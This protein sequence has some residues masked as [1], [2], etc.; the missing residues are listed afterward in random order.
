[1]RRTFFIFFLLLAIF[2]NLPS[3]FSQDAVYVSDSK[4]RQAEEDSR[5]NPIIQDFVQK[6]VTYTLIQMFG[7]V[8]DRTIHEQNIQ[9]VPQIAYSAAQQATFEAIK[10]PALKEI[11]LD[12]YNKGF[13]M[14]IEERD[15]QTPPAA[16]EQMVRR[17]ARS[18]LQRVYDLNEF[19]FLT[20]EILRQAIIQQQQIML[21]YAYQSQ[22]QKMV[23]E[24]EIMN[25]AIQKQYTQAIQNSMIK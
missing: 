1:M 8:F 3:A 18:E 20:E 4:S 24:Q 9:L 25:R 23:M 21:Q 10:Q 6:V 12:T 22:I 2:I 15:K 13:D 11:I 19:R 5:I 7:E 16:I 17:M 14:A